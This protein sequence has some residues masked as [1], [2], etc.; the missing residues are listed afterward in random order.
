VD[1]SSKFGELSLALITM[2]GERSGSSCN[3]GYREIFSPLPEYF[4][5]YSE[6]LPEFFILKFFSNFFLSK[7]IGMIIFCLFEWCLPTELPA[8]QPLK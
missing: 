8:A 2:Q 7:L 1:F 6:E 4:E 5:L 3:L